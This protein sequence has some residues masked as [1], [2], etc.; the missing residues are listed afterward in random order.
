MKIVALIL[1]LSG[2]IED[3]RRLTGSLTEAG[4]IPYVVPTS[5]GLAERLES[6]DVPHLLIYDN[7]G[8]GAAL[9]VAANLVDDWDWLMPVNDDVLIDARELREEVSRWAT[10]DPRQLVYLDPVEPKPIPGLWSVLGQVSLV[11]GAWLRLRQRVVE[12]DLLNQQP[13]AA[14]D[15]FRPFSIVAFDR[16]LWLDLD[17]FDESLIYTFEDAD[18]GRRAIECGAEIAFPAVRGV[19]HS[20]SGTSKR[21]ADKV[22]PVAVWS[23]SRYLVTLGYPSVMARTLCALASV[24]RIAAI[25]GTRIPPRAHLVG[26]LRSVRHLTTNSAPTL[27]AYKSL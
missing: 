10:L 24:V 8:F 16:Q 13:K 5:Y 12:A 7:P 3:L 9:T 27:P 11:G 18:F 14:R 19:V 1:S 15:M 4:V 21:H 26:L 25:P 23:A 22:I 6:S 2:D 20:K 17:G